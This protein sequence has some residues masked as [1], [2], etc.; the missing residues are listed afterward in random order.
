MKTRVISAIVMIVLVVACF[1][2]S[3]I[4]RI[5]FL[6]AVAIMAVWE[7]CRVL[8][9]KDIRCP[10]AILYVFVIAAAAAVYFK[11]EVEIIYAIYFLAVSAAVS[12]GVM[13]KS[14]RAMG[15]IGT[16]FILVYPLLPFVL[17]MKISLSDIWI[18]VFTLACVSTWVCDSFA[19]F[20]GKR[21]GK[22]KLAPEVS[23]HKTI[24][25]TIC[26]AIS[27]VV[28]SIGVYFAFKAYGPYQLPLWLCMVTALV[29]SSFGQMGDLAASLFKRMA[30]LKDY[31]N[32]IPGHGGVMDRV[33]SLLLSIP[34][35]YF[36][37]YLYLISMGLI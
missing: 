9:I 28:F 8:S 2:I 21:F 37:I 16:T 15:T 36:I 29:A 1:A 10:A 31:S 22:N 3:P 4:T 33:D 7:M 17:I 25:G 14:I 24:E 6:A 5:L 27:A 34:C 35:S 23:P 11:A 20:G 26:G 13:S 32:L 30:G 19:L 12:A 18:P